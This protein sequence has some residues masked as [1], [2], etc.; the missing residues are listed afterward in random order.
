MSS[1]AVY[2]VGQ[3]ATLKTYVLLLALL[4]VKLEGQ[5]ACSFLII[6]NQLTISEFSGNSKLDFFL[7]RIVFL[8]HKIA[9]NAALL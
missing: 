5:Y 1:L 4:P 2:F 9:E 8:H 6:L 3:P 7:A